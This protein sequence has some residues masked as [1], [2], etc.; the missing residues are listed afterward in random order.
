[1]GPDAGDGTRIEVKSGDRTF[2]LG[3][4]KD[5][6]VWV[7]V[8]KRDAES[9]FSVASATEVANLRGKT[10]S[11]RKIERA[12]PPVGPTELADAVAAAGNAM[13]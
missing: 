6:D 1:V 9:M 13:R 11:A 3:N 12:F 7:F 8:H 2:T 5:V 10:V 4:A